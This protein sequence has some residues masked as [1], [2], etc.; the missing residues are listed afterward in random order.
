MKEQE[1]VVA[2]GYALFPSQHGWISREA[3]RITME[4]GKYVSASELLRRIV[5]ER[6]AEHKAV[7]QPA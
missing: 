3:A 7:K 6:R 1:Q 4:T 2:K 5:E